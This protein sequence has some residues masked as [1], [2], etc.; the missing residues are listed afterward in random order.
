MASMPHP[1]SDHSTA[2]LF[3]DGRVASRE[4]DSSTLQVYSPPYLFK[5]ARPKILTSPDGIGYGSVFTVD[6]DV[7]SN[8]IGSVA[9]MR[10]SHSTH[11]FDMGQAYV[12]LEFTPSGGTLIVS[13]PANANLAP[14]G[15]YMLFILNGNG[16]PS[17]ARF[18]QLS[19][20]VDLCPWD[21]DGSGSVDVQDLVEVLL[22]FGDPATPPCDTGQDITQDGVVN[23]NDLV[24]VL[25]VFGDVCGP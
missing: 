20:T 1:R 2:P 10:P 14:P 11:S 23:I 12:P 4:Q 22:C 19:G 7:D 13:A 5:G 15:Y 6:P 9:L 3:P 25:L 8:S 21:I 17:V 24:E 16:V 18:V